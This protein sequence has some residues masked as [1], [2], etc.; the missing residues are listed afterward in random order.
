[1]RPSSTLVGD[2]R[3]TPA[4]ARALARGLTN[5]R[6]VPLL[7]R[8]KFLPLLAAADV[9]LITQQR[10]VADVVFPSKV[11]TLLAAGKPV[12]A[13]VA[14]GSAVAQ[15]I[16]RAGA[17][18]VIAPEDGERLADSVAA[19][20]D[21]PARRAEMRAAGRAYARRHWERSSALSYLSGTIE[22]LA[23]ALPAEAR[24]EID[25]R[26]APDMTAVA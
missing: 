19:L 2:G 9:C 6:I 13:S 16:A 18:M 1:M 7:P 25:R 11:L 5:V 22:R 10:V 8:E 23:A 12:I 17:G 15:A 20:R 4:E 3:Q 14:D 26:T 21:Q 24:E